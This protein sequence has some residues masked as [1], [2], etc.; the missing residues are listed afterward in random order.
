ME[1]NKELT[2]RDV[3]KDVIDILGGIMVPVKEVNNIGMP[4]AR[5]INGIQMCL[6]SF[7]RAEAE[8]NA[9]A[10][11]EPAQAEEEQVKEDA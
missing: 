9:Q 11:D 6:D 10:E 8:Q 7:D 1:E 4:I 5:A 2:V 3:L